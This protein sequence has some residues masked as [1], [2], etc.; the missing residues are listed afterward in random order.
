MLCWEDERGNEARV[1]GERESGG[2]VRCCVMLL[3]LLSMARR[4]A[5][6][7]CYSDGCF[8]KEERDW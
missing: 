4:V 2:S 7:D 5:M 3:L 1:G 8:G 6:D